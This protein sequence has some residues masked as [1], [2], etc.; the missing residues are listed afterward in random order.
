VSGALAQAREAPSAPLLPAAIGAAAVKALRD[1]LA[2][3]PKPG[4]VSPVDPGAHPDM[5]ARTFVRAIDA[6]PAFFEAAAEAGAAKVPFT[7][8]RTLGVAAEARMLAATSGINTHR[9]AIFGLGLLAAA[10]GRLGASERT[11]RGAA[12]G[13]EVSARWGASLRAELSPDPCSHGGAVALRHG[14]GGARLEAANGFPHLFRVALPALQGA[15]RRGASRRA[16][17]AQCLLSLIATL[18]D[19]NLLWRGGAGGLAWARRSA[20]SFLD[21]GGVFR[22][23]WEAELVILHQEFT[24]R[25][26]SP[27][28]SADL[29]AAALLVDDLGGGEITP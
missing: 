3:H 7:A 24:R 18:P 2:L 28:G 17:A 11:V 19:T 12:L 15:L 14:V 22:A 8:L 6:L 1:E 23:G 21:A 20:A 9:G 4:L 16:A 29:L 5:D 27:G 25:R 26:L 13:R 10:A